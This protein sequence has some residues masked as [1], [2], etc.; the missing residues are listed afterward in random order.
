MKVV[1]TGF[2]RKGAKK[3]RRRGETGKS[4]QRRKE[5]ETQRGDGEINAELQRSR[6]AEFLRNFASLR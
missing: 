3:Q 5:A 4:T 2:Q 6:D 1:G